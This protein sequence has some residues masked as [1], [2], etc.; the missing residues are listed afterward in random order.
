MNGGQQI[1]Q[2]LAFGRAQRELADVGAEALLATRGC[3][4]GAVLGPTPAPAEAVALEG[5]VER[6]AVRF[7]RIG[8]RSVQ[9]EYQGIDA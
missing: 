8:Q 6:Q 4:Q 3:E 7:L 9:V 5:E 2:T 1:P